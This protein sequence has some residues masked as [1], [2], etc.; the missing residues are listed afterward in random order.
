MLANP[1]GRASLIIIDIESSGYDAASYPIEI[2][3]QD[4]CN[5]DRY[6]HFFI[7]PSVD[8]DFWDDVYQRERH[9]ICRGQLQLEGLLPGEAC[10]RL[11]QALQGQVVFG[12]DEAAQRYWLTLLFHTA[13]Q[14]PEFSLH[15]LFEPLPSGAEA[16][17]QRSLNSQSVVHRALDDARQLCRWLSHYHHR[18][19]LNFG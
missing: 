2:A 18:Q 4:S 5:S 8:W 15:S 3:W 17:L 9:G 12:A 6:D 1:L 16:S 19:V 11:N 13:G 10:Q 7:T 14:A